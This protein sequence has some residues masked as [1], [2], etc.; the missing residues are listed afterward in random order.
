MSGQTF[1]FCCLRFQQQVALY[2][3]AFS[4]HL[5]LASWILTRG[6]SAEEPVGVHPYR[7]WCQQTAHSDS[8]KCPIHVAA[9]R[10][11]LLI[12]KLFV[13][14][15]PY[16]LAC[17][18][19]T[20]HDA[21][22]I[23]IRHGYRDCVCFLANKLC[24]VV[25]FS[26][27]S[28]PM[29]IYLQIKHWVRLGK[30]RAAS[31]WSQYTNKAFQAS[32]GNKMLVDGFSKPRMSYKSREFESKLRLG[33]K[34]KALSPL[35][36]T[37]NL[38]SISH[39]PSKRS[40]HTLPSLHPEKVIQKRQCRSNKNTGLMDE[41]KDRSSS[42]RNRKFVL[43]PLTGERF[44]GTSRHADQTLR[45]DAAYCLTIARFVYCRQSSNAAKEKKSPCA[46][47]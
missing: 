32:V 13:T 39:M 27:T 37:W 2:I 30:K 23:A 29:R 8:K 28:L 33:M 42:L 16:N 20:G 7:Q 4:G 1:F 10:N 31:S 26:N 22:K 35:P 25:S 19:P 12:L 3:A 15:N 24:S 21:L 38:N 17:R 36:H 5:D 9:E 14:K 46:F 40:T 34:S 11:Q 47:H 18:D 45:D 44:A 43:P 6:A 41:T